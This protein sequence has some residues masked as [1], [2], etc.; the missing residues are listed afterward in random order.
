M[1]YLATNYFPADGVQVA[2]D[3]AF[4]GV[5][6]GVVSGTVP[7]LYPEDVRAAELFFDI[8]GNAAFLDRNVIITAPNQATIVGLPVAAGRTVKIYRKT[9]IRFPLVDYRDRQTVSELDLD[10][11]ARQ[12]IFIAQET[13]D[14]AKN[15]ILLDVHDNYDVQDH[16]IVNLAPGV[17]P[18]DAANMSQLARAI[19]TL[20]GGPALL[21]I[22]QNAADRAG[23]ALTFDNSGNP[24]ATFPSAE[25]VIGLQMNLANTT[26]PTKGGGMVYHTTG[27]DL[28]TSMVTITN[29]AA[30]RALSA[31]VLAAGRTIAYFVQDHSVAGKGGGGTW[32]WKAG[33][34][35][36]DDNATVIQP[37]GHVGAG[38][39]IRALTY[40]D[41][42]YPDIFG[43]FGGF[44]W[45][46]QTGTVET[47][48]LQAWLCFLNRKGY[49]GRLRAGN[50][51]LTGTLYLHYDAVL[52]PNWPGRVGRVSIMGHANGHATGAL[53]D[54]GCALVHINGQASA[55][56]NMTG[57][58]SI[59][60]P[61]G[62]GG[63][64]AMLNMNLVG[65]NMT[66]NVLHLQGSSGSI[67]L[68]NYTVKVQNPAGNG[69]LENT[70]WE[71]SHINGLI[72]GG[73]VGDGTWTGVGLRIQSDG[74]FGQTNMKVYI[75]VDCYKMGYGTRIGRGTTP[76]GTFG[77]LTFIGGQTSLADNHGL[78]LEGG[79]IAFTSI[80]YQHEGHRKNGIRIDR[81]LEDGVT[82]ANDLPRAVKI[83][84]SY[85]TGCGAIEDGSTNSYAV[86]IANG[87]NIELDNLVL[88]TAGDGIGFDAGEVD[89]LLI[90]R[91]VW[92][93]VRTYGATSGYGFRAFGTQDAA[94]RIYLEHPTFNQSPAIQ[95]DT[96]AAQVFARGAVGGR[97]SFA[98]NSTVPSIS[99]G[100]ATGGETVK[101]L[102]FNYST[103]VTLDNITGARQFQMLFI[104]FS[105]TNVTIPNNRST[106]FLNG[107]AFTPGNSKSNI[108]LYFDGVAWNE[109]SRSQNT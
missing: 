83:I 31:P 48:Q 37:T 103:T 13:Q 27:S 75:N 98:T 21:E 76:T 43:A 45:A 67:Y 52:N 82:L 36:T 88:N 53:E 97:L 18:R 17:D 59:E 100:G 38:R 51:Y 79:V 90:R 64:F 39:W 9:E 70:T 71:T 25:S 105:N 5:N 85:I 34:N 33:S 23:R 86:Y 7:Y 8:D 68:Q 69:I 92:R 108:M 56:L 78:W 106:F 93:T 89:N 60:N 44:D 47:A 87:D 62:M 22:P 12:A 66:T 4:A 84:S 81:T 107:S 73:A 16:R 40:N 28:S 77:P 29:N 14:A 63:Y 74:T 65:G 26:D 15:S 41:E 102:N 3:F 1:A 35:E 46:T 19:R 57:V 94:K 104:T 55:L 49:V 2:F 54:P 72:R 109:V 10:L 24:V 11:S 6:P 80:G 96:V 95:F 20:A 50:K 101:Q 32:A 42:I 91:P 61:T 99:L 30:L 58:F